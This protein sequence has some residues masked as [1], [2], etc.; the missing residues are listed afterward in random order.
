MEGEGL[1]PALPEGRAGPESQ[2]GDRGAAV[3]NLALELRG[4][5]DP[6]KA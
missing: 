6:P 2:K 4:K 5:G 1:Q 3:H